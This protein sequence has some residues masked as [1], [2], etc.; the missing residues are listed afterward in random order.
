MQW[1]ALPNALIPTVTVVGLMVGALLAGAVV[2]ESVF[3]WPGLGRL[4]AIAVGSRDVAVVQCI[5]FLVAIT[6]V[7]ANLVVDLLYGWLDPRILVHGRR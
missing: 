6:M 4:L 5:L 7:S 2:V 3:S 1:H